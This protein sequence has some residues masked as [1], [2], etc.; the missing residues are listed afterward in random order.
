MLCS[1]G[2]YFAADLD[3]RANAESPAEMYAQQV[4]PL[5]LQH[6]EVW[7][8]AACGSDAFEFCCGM[9]Q[10]RAFHLVKDNWVTRI[11]SH[12]E[13]RPLCMAGRVTTKDSWPGGGV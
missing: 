4:E 8:P 11:Q 3:D 9:V 5:L 7:P 13:G 6:P 10:S 1:I 2:I 12:G